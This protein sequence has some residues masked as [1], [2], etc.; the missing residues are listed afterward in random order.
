MKV[1]RCFWSGL[2]VLSLI[3]ISFYGGTVSYGLFFG[4]TLIPVISLIY[5]ACVYFRFK[6]YQETEKKNLV[7]GQP[8]PYLFILQNEDWFAYTGISV[9]M[10]SSF[11]YAEETFEN[12]EYDYYCHAVS[13]VPDVVTQYAGSQSRNVSV[14]K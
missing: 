7:C 8:T 12:A 6:I 11:S 13:D 3:A 4:I 1:R 10:H 5:L 2:W 14:P 9:R